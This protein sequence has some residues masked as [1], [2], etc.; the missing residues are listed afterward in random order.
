LKRSRLAVAVP[1]SVWNIAFILSFNNNG[2]SDF[3]QVQKFLPI[4]SSLHARIVLKSQNYFPCGS[5]SNN[6][7]TE[8]I[9]IR[10]PTQAAHA[11]QHVQCQNRSD[12]VVFWKSFSD[13]LHIFDFL[14]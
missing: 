2:K 12:Y 6:G 14:H 1:L 13:Q 5:Q 10:K 3:F 8:W 9:L 4:N 7:I 11:V